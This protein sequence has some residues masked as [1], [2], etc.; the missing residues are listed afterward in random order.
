MSPV[1]PCCSMSWCGPTDRNGPVRPLAPLWSGALGARL[2]ARTD[3]TRQLRKSGGF[4]VQEFL[5]GRGRLP[6]PL[7]VYIDPRRWGHVAEWLR[8]GL[9]N[10]LH[11][12]NSGRGLHQSNHKLNQR[13]RLFV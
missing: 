2:A 11:Q 8:S 12:F 6:E 7:I 4:R 9:Q 5:A 10:R 13:L 3:R 1:P